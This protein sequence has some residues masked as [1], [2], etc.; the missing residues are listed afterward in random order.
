MSKF[1]SKKLA[2][3]VEDTLDDVVHHLRAVAGSAGEDAAESL[4]KAAA[5]V[6]AASTAV[7]TQARDQS[8]ILAE[9]GVREAREHPV[10]TTALALAVAGLVGYLVLRRRP[11]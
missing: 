1:F 8:R 4:A 3:D 9:R 11:E 5:A 7:A 10:A 2:G 6:A